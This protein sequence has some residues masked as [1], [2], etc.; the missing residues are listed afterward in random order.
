MEFVRALIPAWA[1]ILILLAVVGAVWAHGYW[2]AWKPMHDEAV[3][4]AAIAD[5]QNREHRQR[6]E[7]ARHAQ[8]TIVDQFNKLRAADRA[9]WD[10]IRLRLNAPRGSGVPPVH[11][12]PGSSAPDPGHG[13]EAAGG[14]GDRDLPVALVDA[15]EVGEQLEQTLQ[16]CQA[17]LRVCAGL[18]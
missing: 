6:E 3:V 2:S 11:P 1:R 14:P 4:A 7:E 12:E 5:G 18:R 9:E 10:R 8:A 15:L 13:L 17:E 16:V